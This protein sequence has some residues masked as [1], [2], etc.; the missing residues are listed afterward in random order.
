MLETCVWLPVFWGLVL[1]C[2]CSERHVDRVFA[3]PPQKPSQKTF[4]WGGV[5]AI[6]L[7]LGAATGLY[8]GG[9]GAALWFGLITL[10]SLI[11]VIILLWRPRL[12]G[13]VSLWPVIGALLDRTTKKTP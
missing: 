1:I 9:I 4:L 11:N 2:A 13:Y 5:C 8:G 6:A 10:F 12:I 7:G 3:K